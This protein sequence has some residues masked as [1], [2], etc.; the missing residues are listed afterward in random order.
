MPPPAQVVVW[1]ALRSLPLALG[2]GV[3]VVAAVLWLYPAQ[4]RRLGWPWR[5]VL[6]ALRAAALL[7]LVISLLQPVGMRLKRADERGALLVLIDRS[8]SMGVV[9]T[10]RPP[11]QL[12]ALADGLGRLP[13]SLHDPNS[14]RAVADAA[15]LDALLGEVQRAAV[16]L[17]YAHVA[18]RGVEAARRR[19]EQAAGR[20]AALARTMA[21][22]AQQFARESELR[23]RLEQLGA[24][25]R[26]AGAAELTRTGGASAGGGG[27]LAQ[28]RV[29]VEQTRAAAA[30]AQADADTRLYESDP[31]ARAAADEVAAMSRLALAEQALVRPGSGALR[32]LAGR[33]PFAGFAVDDATSPIVLAEPSGALKPFLNLQPSGTRS[34]LVGALPAALRRLGGRP[35]RAAVLLSDGRQVGGEGAGVVAGLTA[36]G[37][38]AGGVPVFAVSVAGAGPPHD[39]SFA[40]VSVPDAA[41]VG[42]T[43]TVRADIRPGLSAP[44]AEVRLGVAGGSSEMPEQ[45]RRLDLREGQPASVEFPLKLDAASAA[46]GACRIELSITPVP[47]EATPENNRVERWVKVLPRRVRVAAFAGSPGWDFQYLR[48]ALARAPWVELTAQVLSDPNGQRIGLTPNQI[49]EQD[50]LLLSDLPPT[51]LDREQW[52]AANDLVSRRGGSVVLVA[53]QSA[54]PGGGWQ[55]PTTDPLAAALLPFLPGRDFRPVWRVFPGEQPWFRF[56]PTPEA[57]RDGDDAMRLGGPFDVSD[58]QAWQALP[59]VYRFLGIPRAKLKANTEPLLAESETG[60]AVLTRGRFGAGQV[61]FVGLDETWRWRLRSAESYQERFWL[62]LLRSAAGL[63]YAADRGALAL[64]AGKVAAAPGEPMTVRARVLPE[65]A[66]VPTTH[67]ES[68]AASRLP[69]SCELRIVRDD[70]NRGDTPYRVQRLRSAGPTG[71]G[72]YSGTVEGLPEGEYRLQLVPPAGLAG[73]GPPLEVPLHVAPSAEAELAD[74]SGDEAALRRMAESSGGELLAI[75]HVNHLAERVLVSVGEERARYTELSLWDSPYLFA[76]VVA[77]L[78]TEWGLRKR[79]GM[80]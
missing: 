71:S 20:F 9:D 47:G 76:F 27:W 17:E 69:P 8:R 67:S 35:V 26:P 3:V 56:T 19:A 38:G 43:V 70:G 62:Q 6:P 28:A 1:H 24:L 63:P 54:L 30:A 36:A 10:G 74:V 55:R 39:L 77:C 12:I 65:R 68:T 78:G 52:Q 73:A 59:G 80:A 13:P 60:L 64:D 53:G 31:E 75:E 32:A 25:A 48:A 44:G 46:A 40:R 72:L 57:R 21:A 79:F 16:D 18:G 66:A 14:A 29:R 61:F 22:N 51:A 50:V 2:A 23:V 11:A 33:M 49:R 34:D 58:A 4:V 15:R 5:W 7:A 37:G 45:V 41:F 42:E